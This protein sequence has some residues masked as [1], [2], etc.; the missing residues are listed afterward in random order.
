MAFEIDVLAYDRKCIQYIDIS[1][2]ES[3]NHGN[4]FRL[5]RVIYGELCKDDTNKYFIAATM[6]LLFRNNWIG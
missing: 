2:E 1:T 5:P 6:N 4:D 3:A